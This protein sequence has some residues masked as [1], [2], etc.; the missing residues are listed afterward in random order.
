MNAIINT[1]GLKMGQIIEVNFDNL[2]SKKDIIY[3]NKLISLIFELHQFFA[4]VLY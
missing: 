4:R 2:D 1:E 3:K